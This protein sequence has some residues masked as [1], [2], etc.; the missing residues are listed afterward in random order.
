MIALA[1]VVAVGDRRTLRADWREIETIDRD[2]RRWL[3]GRKTPQGRFKAGQKINAIVTVAFAVLFTISG[4]LLWLSA[5]DSRF[6]WE[7]PIVVHDAL[8]YAA[9]VLV[10]GHLYLAVLHPATRHAL[11]G[12]TRGDVRE[13]WAQTHHAKWVEA[14]ESE[15][16]R[17]ATSSGSGMSA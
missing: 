2:D 6:R 15:R 8:T 7:G 1:L 10:L 5:R 9:I 11:R 3:I 14:V 13:D 4:V 17:G 12:M 16:N